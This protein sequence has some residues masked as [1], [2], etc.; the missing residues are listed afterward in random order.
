MVTINKY[1]DLQETYK[2]HETCVVKIGTAWCGPCKLVQKNIENLEKIH[3]DVYF[4]NVSADEADDQILEDYGVMSVPVTLVVKEGK[5]ISR[6][7]GMQ[8]EAQLEER[9]IIIS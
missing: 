6:V 5:V 2:S 8:T 1:D 4:I 3:P 7:V 9:L